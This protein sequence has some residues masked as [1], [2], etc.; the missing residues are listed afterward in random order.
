MATFGAVVGN[1]DGDDA[2]NFADFNYGAD[3]D[4]DYIIRAKPKRKKHA[5]AGPNKRPR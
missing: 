2:P 3:D 5:P 4:L 1:D